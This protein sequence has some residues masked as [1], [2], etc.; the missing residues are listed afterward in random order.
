[1]AVTLPH[2]AVEAIVRQD[3][4]ESYRVAKKTL[5]DYYDKSSWLHRDDLEST[6]L[7]IYHLKFV[8]EYYGGTVD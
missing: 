4:E 6:S 5:D 2:E 1:M 7:A 3:L 8:L